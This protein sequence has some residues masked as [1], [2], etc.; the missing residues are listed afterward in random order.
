MIPIPI[1]NN[2]QQKRGD[3]ERGGHDE[4][5]RNTT[6]RNEDDADNVPASFSI[7][8]ATRLKAMEPR[9]RTP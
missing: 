4:R 5:G 1:E 6:G 8:L 9:D 2:Q 3:K 7:T